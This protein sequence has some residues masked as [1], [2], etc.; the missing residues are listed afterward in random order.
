MRKVAFLFPGQGQGSIKVGM[1]KDIYEHSEQAWIIFSEADTYLKRRFS[2]ICFFGPKEKLLKTKNAQLA[3]LVVNLAYAAALSE[4]EKDGVDLEFVPKGVRPDYLA[5]HSVGYTA[6]LVYAGVITFHQA[7]DI[8]GRRG[9]LMTEACGLNPGR[10]IVLINPKISEVES[11]CRRY[12]LGGNFNSETQTVLSG[13][14]EAIA[15][16]EQMIIEQKIARKILPLHTEG[17]FHSECMRPAVKP[18]REFLESFLF[19][20]PKIPIIGNS[21]AQIITTADEAKKESVEH[22]CLPVLWRESMEVLKKKGVTRFIEMGHGEVLSD[23]LQRNLVIG[24]ISFSVAFAAYLL[25]RK[26]ND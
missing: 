18:F 3:S 15:E 23:N 19:Q 22:L 17:G 21:Q 25:R 11:I 2:R 24:A 1:G 9:D 10:M 16:A 5:G 8:V 13:P 14:V 20:D 4:L 26:Q 6:A 12:K 7:L